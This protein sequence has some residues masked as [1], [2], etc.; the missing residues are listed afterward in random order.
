MRRQ[1]L[2]TSDHHNER[3]DQW[4]STT[5]H[6]RSL[7]RKQFHKV[8]H[9]LNK[10]DGMKTN[11][12]HSSMSGKN[13]H[14]DPCVSETSDE[15]DSEQ[16]CTTVFGI[17]NRMT[18]TGGTATKRDPI[19]AEILFPFLFCQVCFQWKYTGTVKDAHRICWPCGLWKSVLTRENEKASLCVVW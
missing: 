7:R 5:R 17:S 19:K 1:A 2:L 10:K 15:E 8:A 6:W 16:S 9:H 14:K 13:T 4:W 12:N 18:M 11:S 3:V